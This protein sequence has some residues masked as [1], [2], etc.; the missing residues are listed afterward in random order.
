[1][2]EARAVVFDWV[3]ELS[4]CAIRDGPPYY[5]GFKTWDAHNQACTMRTQYSKSAVYPEEKRREEV[6]KVR[7]RSPIDASVDLFSIER[8]WNMHIVAGGEAKMRNHS[9]LV[10]SRSLVARASDLP[11]HSS[12]PETCRL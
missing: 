5:E 3:Q 2:I 1:M 7:T 8:L 6:P 12:T 10:H 9:H 11:P 4:I